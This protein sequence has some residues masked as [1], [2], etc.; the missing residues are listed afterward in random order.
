MMSATHLLIA[1]LM[2]AALMCGGLF[3]YAATAMA[4]GRDRH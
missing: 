1:N 3:E 2:V 4:Y